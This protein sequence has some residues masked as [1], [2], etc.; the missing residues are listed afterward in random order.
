MDIYSPISITEE[1]IQSFKPT[2][3]YIKELN[4]L[5]YFGKSILEN[6]ETYTG[7]GRRWKNHIKKYGR[8]NI[9]T[10]WVSEWFFEPF[11]LQEF[12]VALSAEYDIVNSD[13][14]ANLICENGLHGGPCINNFFATSDYNKKIRTPEEKAAKGGNRKGSKDPEY[15]RKRKADS[16]RTPERRLKTSLAMSGMKCYNNGIRTIRSKIPPGEG[17]ISGRIKHTHN[18]VIL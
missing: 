14:W 9:K 11:T 8:N 15:V 12:A 7:S 16:A 13:K 6:I 10:I 1:I 5:K 2:R 17:W 4:G 3:L 18:Q